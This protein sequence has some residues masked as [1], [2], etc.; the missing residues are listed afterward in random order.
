[1]KNFLKKILIIIGAIT[2]LEIIVA[3]GVGVY[4]FLIYKEEVPDKTFIEL[5][6]EK[7][8]TEYVPDDPT[9]RMIS[10]KVVTIRDVVEALERASG[11]DQIKGVIARIGSVP[12]GFA[13]IQ[14]I[15]DAILNFRQKGKT[16]IA[17]TDTF[18]E[19]GPGN[20]AYY[21]ATA[22]EEICLQPSGDIGLTGLILETRFMKGTLDKLGV[23]P[24]MD[25]RHEYKNAM[26]IFTEKE[27]T[28]P[29]KEAVCKV[30]ESLFGQIVKEIAR[31]REL[32][33]EDVRSLADHGLFLGQEAVNAKLADKLAYQDEVYEDVKKNTGRNTHFL[34]L[35]DYLNLAGRVHTEG[36]TIALIYGVG[37]V[38][39]GESDYNPLYGDVAMGAKTVTDAFQAA[40]EDDAVRAIVFRVSSPGGSYVASDSIWRETVRAKAA[41]KPVIVSMGD[42]AGSGGYFV[43]MNADKIVAHPATIT[44]SIGVLAGKMVTSGFWDKLGISWDDVSTS[45]NA[46]I[47]TGTHDYTSEEWNLLEGALDRIYADF[48]SKV[49]QGRGLPIEYVSEIAKGRIWTGEDAKELGLVDEL[50]GFPLAIRLA[51]EAAEIPEDAEICLK[52]FPKKKPL[53]EVLLE[54]GPFGAEEKASASAAIR[55]LHELQPMIQ[56]VRELAIKD[57]SKVLSMPKIEIR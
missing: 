1:M 44:G 12:M 39:R 51:K 27:Y 37:G 38:Q 10:G 20:R 56:A 42:V 46:A 14:E 26:N 11:D 41:G 53:L 45:S 34:S 35:S 30:M 22:F 55:V 7:G 21:L 5:D 47:W 43:A 18:G 6:F 25:H 8:F 15:R 50:G 2:L 3:I 28:A 24:R 31:T 36:E 54:K 13:R 57:E 49:A 33:E 32:S 4:F 48:T 17:Y 52:V 40:T 9:A 29:H 19:F 16:A 23:I